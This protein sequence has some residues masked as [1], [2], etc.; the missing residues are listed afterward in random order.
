[1]FGSS[2][3][4][5]HLSTSQGGCYGSIETVA[6][7][8]KAT[9]DLFNRVNS[10]SP[11]NITPADWIST[12]VLAADLL[13]NETEYVYFAIIKLCSTITYILI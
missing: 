9:W 10:L 4:I 11:T 8:G 1:L 13:K 5:N 12:F 7:L 6:G 3:T 2:H